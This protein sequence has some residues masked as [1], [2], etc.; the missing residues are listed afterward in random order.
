MTKSNL[1]KIMASLEDFE[2]F[3]DISKNLD[4]S[5]F[6]P[7]L[8]EAQ[9]QEI[10]SFLGKALYSALQSDYDEI[11][12]EFSEDR[13]TDLWFGVD[14][15]LKGHEVRYNGLKPALIYYTYERI[16]FNNRL[17]VTRYGTRV[18]EDNELSVEAG[19]T[20]RFEV[21]SDSMGLSYQNDSDEFI[22]QNRTDYPEFNRP[23]KLIKRT[24]GLKMFKVGK[25]IAR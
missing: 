13:F 17:N 11:L 7:F 10:R 22:R 5:R 4:D 3:R 2:D 8:M 24:T 19:L 6:K 16:V 9:R 18:L 12:D 23:N 25:N 15:D 1:D 21:S 20:K 14:Y